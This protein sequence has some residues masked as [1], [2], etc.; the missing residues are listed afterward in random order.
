MTEP[1]TENAK[2]FKIWKNPSTPGGPPAYMG[3]FYPPNGQFFF[4]GHDL[5]NLGFLP[6]KYS[7]LA[8]KSHSYYGFFARWQTVE[9]AE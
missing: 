1:L 9:V 5:R 6:G 4:F 3:E 2:G 7:V 8:P